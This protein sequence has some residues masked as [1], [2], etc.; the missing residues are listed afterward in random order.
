[1]SAVSIDRLVKRYAD[2]TAVD[3]LSL[4]V[5]HGE[6][7]GLLG[8]NGAGKSTTI[9]VLCGLLRADSGSVRIEGVSAADR[10]ARRGLGVVFQDTELYDDLTAWENLVFHA[11][12]YGLPRAQRKARIEQALDTALL[13]DCAR[14]RVST[15]SGG[16]RRRLALARSL[17]HDPSVL[18]LDEPTLGIDV[19]ARN[20]IWDRIR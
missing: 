3:E 7:V 1:M 10:R 17:M 11:R 4:S 14:R 15:F 8:P 9:G 20:A 16:M 12:L 5:N 2:R 19:Q 18:L 6:V 13:Q